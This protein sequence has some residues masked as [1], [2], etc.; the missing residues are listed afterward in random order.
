MHRLPRR[1]LFLAAT[2]AISPF[3]CTSFGS[4]PG[5]TPDAQPSATASVPT[6][7]TTPPGSPDA[8]VPDGVAA[9]DATVP[10]PRDAGGPLR[11]CTGTEL[12]A[13][14]FEGPT[15]P[16]P[17]F[18]GA[19]TLVPQVDTPAGFSNKAITYPL[20]MGT[21]SMGMLTA[22][23]PVLGTPTTL[24]FEATV[25]LTPGFPG[26]QG[27][28]I[29]VLRVTSGGMTVR[30]GLS[31]TGP[32]LA[33]SNPPSAMPLMGINWDRVFHWVVRLNGTNATFTLDGNTVLVQAVTIRPF[34]NL[35][36]ELGFDATSL[37]AA[38][39]PAASIT[40]DDVHATSQ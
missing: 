33:S 22:E 15:V 36:V 3:A 6:V 38:A 31:S 25:K 27:G 7:P 23:V 26:S 13:T 34:S 12:V 11:A 37:A 24:C 10:P 5:D 39:V 17:P 35:K 30:I 9:E 19:G 18:T 2:A 20:P 29:D 21:A 40:F 16:A 14:G 32:F 4:D 1:A 28:E 8:N